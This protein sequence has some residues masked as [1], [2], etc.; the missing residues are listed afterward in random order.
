MGFYGR[1]ST[2]ADV[3]DAMTSP[4][5]LLVAGADQATSPQENAAFDQALTDAGK[6]HKTVI[7]DGAPHSF[8]DRSYAQW[9]QACA[10][11]WREMLGFIDAYR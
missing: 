5:L 7:Y 9:E 1:P 11:A 4:L 8:F 3:V 2:A 6:D 10:D